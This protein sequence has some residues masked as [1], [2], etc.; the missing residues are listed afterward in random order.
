MDDPT[1]V[2]SQNGS[3]RHTLDEGFSTRNRKVE[4][5]NPSSG[6]KTAGQRASLAL[7]TARRHQAV[8]P[9]GCIIAPPPRPTRFAT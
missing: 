5:S 3:G 4:G 1:D 7:P 8:I 6:S 9:L 2:S